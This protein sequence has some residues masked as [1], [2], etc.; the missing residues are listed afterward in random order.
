MAASPLKFKGGVQSCSGWRS[1]LIKP[2]GLSAVYFILIN[3]FSK[4]KL[5][6]VGFSIIG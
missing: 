3:T 5:N 1:Q 4:I 6:S 2:S